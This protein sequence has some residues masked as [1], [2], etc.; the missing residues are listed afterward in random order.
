[1]T[2]DLATTLGARTQKA[3]AGARSGD[4]QLMLGAGASHGASN[5][6]G[7]L[8]MS[9]DLVSILSTS[10]P[11]AHILPNTSLARAY[12]RAIL[13][14]SA[15]HVWQTLR[16]IFIGSIHEAWFAQ[17]VGMPWRRIWTL[18][19]DD[20]VE[21]TYQNT[22]RAATSK[23]RAISWHEPY[24]ETGD[25]EIIHLH[26][27]VLSNDPTP[28]VF[29]FSEYQAAARERPVWAQVL[30]GVLGT[31]PVV[32]LGARLLD[33]P[34]VESLLMTNRP[35][36]RAP[37]MFVDPYVSDD[38][39]WELEK[40]GYVVIKEDAETF[41]NGWAETFALDSIGLAALY[42]AST[43]NI[44]QIIQLQTNH[45]PPAPRSH[46]YYG[47]DEPQWSDIVDNK[48]ALFDWMRKLIQ[49]IEEWLEKTGPKSK[50]H[51]LY[52]RRLT[53]LSSGILA[54]AREA[55][56]RH[57]SVLQFD[58]SSR[59]AT[60]RLMDY[61]RGRGPV[62]LIIDG[63]SDFGDDIDR[64]LRGAV[65][66]AAVELYCLVSAL[67]FEDLRLE[68]RLTG[69]YPKVAEKVPHSLDGGDS[70]A[71]VGKL[72][73]RGRLGALEPM[74][75]DERH[76]H[77]RN[78]DIFSGLMEVEHSKGFGR[79]LEPE[80]RG[81]DKIWKENLLLLLALAGQ[82][83]RDVGLQESS[84][85]VGVSVNTILEAVRVDS[86]LTALVEVIGTLLY[87]RQRGNALDI[88]IELR[89]ESGALQGLCEMI[90]ALA[91]IATRQG[92]RERNRAAVLLGYLMGAKMLT[93]HF[94][95]QDIDSFYE[96]LRT[97]FG[98]W[99]GRYWEQRAIHSKG[100]R[101]WPAAE[102]FAARAVSLYDDAFTRTTYGTVLINRAEEFSNALSEAWVDFYERGRIQ[103][104]QARSREP[105]NRVTQFAYLEAT[106]ALLGSLL[107]NTRDG[108]SSSSSISS[109]RTADISAEWRASYSVL[110]LSLNHAA[111]FKTVSRIERLSQRYELL[112][113]ASSEFE[114]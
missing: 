25:L 52:A 51:I 91:P 46:D 27:H 36:G 57:M 18:N 73:D 12:Q 75:A 1:M 88:I 89:G 56:H 114:I 41:V 93:T 65:K 58:K 40:L 104:D 38:S 112:F 20:T 72:F 50:L 67:P 110:R 76:R 102:S 49:E 2:F 43:I 85:A 31:K 74:T 68:G 5:P 11:R 71:I 66:D 34:D 54:I 44:P 42:A 63:A 55:R 28:V 19:V 30:G 69:Q 35:T 105:E 97:T 9:T 60:D 86:N 83:N 45:V 53:G 16:T 62:L 6:R 109:E 37:S 39:R 10:Y 77:F 84:F 47:G 94:P 111:G 4:Y 59:F 113:G 23:M 92:L 82:G 79:R 3:E 21:N 101:D 29:S 108:R 48:A 17:L 61:C 99:N 87:S 8:P 24:S 106:L 103:F 15:S 26:G 90:R 7:P 78:R 80:I 13:D 100:I 64:L 81:L 14:S 95:N 70:R 22:E 98:D 32:S 33:D 96:T 107:V